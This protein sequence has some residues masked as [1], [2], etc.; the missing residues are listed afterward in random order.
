MWQNDGPCGCCLSR[1]LML[2]QTSSSPPIHVA[3]AVNPNTHDLHIAWAATVMAHLTR[4]PVAAAKVKTI[5]CESFLAVLIFGRPIA[6]HKN[7]PTPRVSVHC[8]WS[9][10]T[11]LI[12]KNDKMTLSGRCSRYCVG[13][14]NASS[15][16]LT[17]EASLFSN[18]LS[19]CVDLGRNAFC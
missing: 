1:P 3:D 9:V 7:F 11:Y 16:S 10:W 19:L 18:T 12:N 14:P 15:G 4:S 17:I 13:S 2:L 6:S 5:N 8:C